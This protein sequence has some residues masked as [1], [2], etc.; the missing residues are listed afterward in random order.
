MVSIAV[1][2]DEKEI[3]TELESI[4]IDIFDKLNIDL[5]IDIYFSGNKLCSKMEQQHHYDLI[6]LDIK[7]AK[8]EINGVEV[9]Q[10]I[11]DVQDND[12][13]SIVYISWE[14]K[15]AMQL[16]KIRPMDFLVKPL[17]Y[18]KIEQCV[19]THLKI[20]KLLSGV[21]IYKKGHDTFKLQI[22]EIIY[23]ENYKRK[24]IIHFADGRED[25]FYG[26]LKQIYDE[27]LKNYDFLFIH[28]S[29]LVN[30]DF[31]MAVKYNHVSIINYV[32]PLPISPNRRNEVRSNYLEIT[33]R[34]RRV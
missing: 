25:F 13:V 1:C 27:Q 20:A 12:I 21:F 15:Y 23:F 9:G 14:K 3:C 33:K 6:F 7:F 18:N 2:D 31:V 11:R 10:H 4:L 28:A 17:T 19:K 30:Y 32:E 5:E 16:F 8:N 34:R 26:S 24:V 22:K 29:F